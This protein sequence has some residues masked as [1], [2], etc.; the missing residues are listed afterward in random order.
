M[1][2]KRVKRKYI[3]V[4]FA[5]LLFVIAFIGGRGMF[6]AFADTAG[7]TNVLTDLQKDSKFNVGEYSDD[8]ND[9]EIKSDYYS[10]QVIQ[11]AESTGGELFIYTYQPCQNITYL[12][13]LQV[14]MAL[15]DKVGFEVTPDTQL[16]DNDKPKLYDLTLLSCEG[17]FCKYKVNDFTVSSDTVRYYNIISLF[18]DFIDGDSD[19][20]Y[21]NTTEAVACNVGRLYKAET[22]DGVV[23]YYCKYIDVMKILNPFVGFF[24][25]YDGMTWDSALGLAPDKYTDVH[26][27]AFTPD[28][29]IDTLKEADITYRTQSYHIKPFH[30]GTDYGEKSAPQYVTLTGEM[31]DS[32]VGG[33]GGLKFSWKCIQ[34]TAEFIKSINLTEDNVGYEYVKNSEFVLVFYKTPFTDK[35]VY[36]FSQ[37]H[38]HEIKG[39]KVSNVSILRLM[40]DTAGKTYNLGTLMNQQTGS[41]IPVNANKPVGFWAFIWRCIVR[42][43]NG[44]ATLSEQIVAVVALFFVLLFVPIVLTVLSFVFPVFGAVMKNIFKG[45][46]I[47]IKYLFIGLWYVISSPVRLIIWIVHKKKGDG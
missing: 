11:I 14:N 28:R 42:L 17:V 12:V 36:S 5:L 40:F 45:L 46:W 39:T 3:T 1:K 37:G 34:R 18:R 16:T 6:P 8:I 10:I 43:F 27:I 44:T 15:T 19:A 31:K 26:F 30:E 2:N 23:K 24:S 20:G 25:F 35:E 32:S 7:Y 41:N 33:F 38:S 4:F 22:I 21:D 29:Q 13:A 9:F 47:G